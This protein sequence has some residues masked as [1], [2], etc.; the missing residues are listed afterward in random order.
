MG[1]LDNESNLIIILMVVIIGVFIVS[2]NRTKNNNNNQANN[3]KEGFDSETNNSEDKQEVMIKKKRNLSNELK[4]SKKYNVDDLL[5]ILDQSHK[6]KSRHRRSKKEKNKHR[7]AKIHNDD[8]YEDQEV[9]GEYIEMKYHSD[10]ND[11]ITAIN[12]LTPQRELFNMGFLPVKEA[13]PDPKNINEL[14]HLFM[15]KLNKEVKNNVQEFLHTNSGWNDMGK[16]RREKSGYEEQMEELGLPSSIY[17]EPAGKASV[18]LIKIDKAEQFNTN[19]QIRF[20]VHIIVQK[21]NVKDQMVLKVQFFL[22]REDMK[23][24]GDDRADF[25][26]KKIDDD[27]N[28]NVKIDPDQV[29]V[30]EQVFTL[31]YLTDSAKPRTK[32]DKFHDYNNVQRQDGTFDQEKVIKTMLMKHKERQNELNS[33]MCTVDNDTKEI[34]D[35]PGIDSYSVYKNTRTIMDDLAEFPHRQFGDIKM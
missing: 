34:H 26:E 21:E 16:R 32:S 15:N 6:S 13:I 2:H 4:Y 35:I 1:L 27:D 19:D 7:S 8:N 10:Y 5:N 9:N 29:A 14:V 31:G 18:R 33:F 25:F 12:N 23:G 11:T 3:F 20:V 30:I 24:R 17:T 28:K 22:E